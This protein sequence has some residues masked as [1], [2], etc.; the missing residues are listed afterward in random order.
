VKQRTLPLNS[1]PT[2]EKA[3][4]E[5]YWEVIRQLDPELYKLK[6]LLNEFRVNPVILES[7]IKS[8][9][10]LAYGSGYGKIQI[11]MQNRK[12]TNV[13]PEESNEVN[14]EALLE[15]DNIG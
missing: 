10:N 7:V 11:F 3:N 8:I 14:E 6:I 1:L 13:K 2:E 12:I 9:S 5:K 4:I 15:V